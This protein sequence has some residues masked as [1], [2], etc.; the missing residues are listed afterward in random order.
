MATLSHA[1]VG[2]ESALS[3]SAWITCFMRLT[4]LLA[5]MEG[6]GCGLNRGIDNVLD[7]SPIF[8]FFT[9]RRQLLRAH[10]VHLIDSSA[11]KAENFRNKQ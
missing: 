8:A 10:S 7:L 9:V 1:T 2:Q 5:R 11:G 3:F 6:Q 4:H